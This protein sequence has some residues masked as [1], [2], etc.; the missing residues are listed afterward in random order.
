MSNQNS[1]PAMIRKI[2]TKTVCG[3]VKKLVHGGTV[4]AKNTAIMRV[5]GHV[6]ALKDGESDFGPWVAFIGTF[7]ATNLLTG[8]VYMSAKALL[9]GVI[10]DLIEGQLKAVQKDDPEATVQFAVEVTVSPDESVA[11]GYT[12]GV[13]PLI[14]RAADPLDALRLEV[15]EKA[16]L[17][18]EQKPAKAPAKK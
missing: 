7:E 18:L 5:L 9:P 15:N 14:Q 8:E 12:Y 4:T 17:Q 6:Q 16:P 10:A 13:T 3:D 1:G 2:T 11:I